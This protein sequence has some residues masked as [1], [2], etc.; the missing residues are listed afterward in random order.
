MNLSLVSFKKAA[1]RLAAEISISVAKAQELLATTHGFANFD[2]A[3]AAMSKPPESGVSAVTLPPV[4][5]TWLGLTCQQTVALLAVVALPNAATEL[6]QNR[7]LHLFKVVAKHVFASKPGGAIR[8]LDLLATLDLNA[9]ET[10]CWRHEE[11][12]DRDPMADIEV[13]LTVALPGYQKE[14][15]LDQRQVTMDQHSYLTGPLSFGLMK[16]RAL[17]KLPA[18]SGTKLDTLQKLLASAPTNPLA[19]EIIV[20]EMQKAE[21]GG[22]FLGDARLTGVG[23]ALARFRESQREALAADPDYADAMPADDVAAVEWLISRMP[24]SGNI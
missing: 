12:A 19:A 4:G 1:K 14:R 10:A 24:E 3:V 6:W 2:A 23:A 20:T 22:E 9:L 13:Y 16:L 21:F 8:I 17:E 15:L 7:S 5:P 11:G 18:M